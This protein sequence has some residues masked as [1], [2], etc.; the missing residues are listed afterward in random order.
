MI[1]GLSEKKKMDWKKKRSFVIIFFK[2]IL[3]F[4]LLLINYGHE[5][6]KTLGNTALFYIPLHTLHARW[7]E[8]SNS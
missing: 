4:F 8:V 2:T 5:I 6:Y 1:V 7:S 3:F